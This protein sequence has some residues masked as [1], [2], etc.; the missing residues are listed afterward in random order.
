ML[1]KLPEPGQGQGT[2]EPW[3][4]RHPYINFEPSPH[5]MSRTT[6]S[7]NISFQGPFSVSAGATLAVYLR[8][9]C[10]ASQPH[11]STLIWADVPSKSNGNH[12]RAISLAASLHTVPKMTS[13]GRFASLLVYATTKGLIRVPIAPAEDLAMLLGAGHGDHARS[14]A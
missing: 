5:T 2:S 6:K 3:Q 1:D 10:T 7:K 8:T 11:F 14:P 9:G 12:H 13:T 4:E